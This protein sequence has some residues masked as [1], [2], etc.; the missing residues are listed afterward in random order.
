MGTDFLFA[1]P[2]F[3]GGM[4]SALDLSGILVT[5]YN[6][7]GTPNLADSRAMKSDWAITG[8]DISDTVNQLKNNISNE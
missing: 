2:S 5:E 1:R 7:S 4:A 6:R 3:L 8:N